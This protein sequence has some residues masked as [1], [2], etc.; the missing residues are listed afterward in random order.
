MITTDP[1]GDWTWEATSDDPSV[2]PSRAVEVAAA[3]WNVL[4]R[5]GIATPVAEVS[6]TVRSV[7]DMR[8]IR[9]E[10]TGLPLEEEPLAPHTALSRAAS[11]VDSLQGDFVVAVRMCCPGV[12]S[13]PG[14]RHR[15]EQLF[16]IQADVWK[17]SLVA[18]TLETYSDAWLTMDTRGREQIATYG[19]N[20]PRL[21][22]ALKEVSELFGCAPTPGDENRYAT[23]TETGFEDIRIAGPAY[24]D[25]WGTFEIPARSRRLRSSLPASEDEY[26]ETTENP[27]YYFTVQ[28]DTGQILGYVWAA[29]A[30]N[31]A[32]FEPRT[33][34]GERAFAAGRACVMQL[35]EAHRLGLPALDALSWLAQ[36]P[37]QGGIGHIPEREPRSS[38]SL[39]SL[40][41]LSG[42]W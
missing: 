38:P 37:I 40:E 7:G 22:L 20:A 17:R 23:P 16:T 39:D 24:I 41:E 34:A 21:A 2:Q 33:A 31:A 1:I 8:D 28:D 3:V 11:Q 36:Q 25:A 35:R 12:W 26:S 30:D 9:F 19:E 4:A 5:V 32:G 13:V 27:V 42:S 6:V 15:A 29:Q 18:V 10:E 14:A